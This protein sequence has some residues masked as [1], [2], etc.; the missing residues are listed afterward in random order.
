MANSDLLRNGKADFEITGAVAALIV[1]QAYCLSAHPRLH[2]VIE[3]AEIGGNIPCRPMEPKS[4]YK[5]I[6]DA[7]C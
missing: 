4:R 7:L 1:V 6:V 2:D 5:L 3:L